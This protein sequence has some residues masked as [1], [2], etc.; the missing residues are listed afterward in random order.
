VLALSA[1]ATKKDV[2]KGT[3]AGF[4]RYMTMPV[5]INEVVQVIKTVIDGV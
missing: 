1:A 4:L 5:Q 2:E 3:D